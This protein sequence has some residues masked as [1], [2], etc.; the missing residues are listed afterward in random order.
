MTC[1]VRVS[2]SPGDFLV[3]AKSWLE[4]REDHHN[5]ILG[6]ASARA[7]SAAWHEGEL[8]ATVEQ[9]GAVVG[10]VVRTPPHKALVTD[11]PLES[12]PYVAAALADR[13]DAIPAIFGPRAAAEAVAHAWAALR[14]VRYAAGMPQGL[15][16]LD[17][18][19]P[20]TGVAGA[21]RRGGDADVDLAVEWGEGFARDTGIG[22]PSGRDSVRH[23]IDRAGLYFWEHQ[24]QPVS[25]A[26]AQGRTRR[27]V[28]IG[29]VYTPPR[30]RGLGFA[31]ALV[32]ELS[33][34]MLDAG[35]DFCVLYTDLTNPA[36]NA[37]YRRVG[38]E[39]I[40]E[41]ADFDLE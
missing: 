28:R 5:L 24:E 40:A 33:Q 3:R 34:T 2:E 19:E 26:V 11:L 30:Q 16:R 36:S 35:C 31:R 15:Y 21:M 22:F 13:F 41:L 25:V 10:C 6:L 12:A 14:G 37:L 4:H 38:Y 18:V 1:H 7:G 23:W 29:F 9:D 8:F 20:V 39:L 32:A 17:R 27:G